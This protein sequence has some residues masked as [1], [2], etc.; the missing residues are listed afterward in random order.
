MTRIRIVRIN[1]SFSIDINHNEENRNEINPKL[2]RTGPQNDD[3]TPFKLFSRYIFRPR[4]GLMKNISRSL[5][6]D[7]SKIY[8]IIINLEKAYYQYKS[9]YLLR[10]V[11]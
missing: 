9:K 7:F 3:L 11:N 10:I 6:R 5:G 8:R 1:A 4:F 2:F